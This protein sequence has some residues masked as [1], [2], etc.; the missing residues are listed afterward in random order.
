[1]F[2]YFQI[3]D[4]ETDIRSDTEK[5]T[6][7][8]LIQEVPTRWNNFLYM[9]TRILETSSALNQTIL[10]MSKA[11]SPLTNDVL[12][13]LKLKKTL[14]CISEATDRI[15]GTNYVT[16]SLIYS[17]DFRNLQQFVKNQYHFNYK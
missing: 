2:K 6:P 16:V 12:T 3:K 1:M 9:I 15:Q 7:Y 11:P 4:F 13:I 8:K 5:R 14:V 17:N 10:K